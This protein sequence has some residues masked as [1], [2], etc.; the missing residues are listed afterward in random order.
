MVPPRP[1]RKGLDHVFTF[2]AVRDAHLFRKRSVAAAGTL[3]AHLA[4]EV[5]AGVQPLAERAYWEMDF[6][7]QGKEV[8]G[9]DPKY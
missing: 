4:R 9:N 8:W 5:P 6:P 1:D 3:F 2:S 7:A